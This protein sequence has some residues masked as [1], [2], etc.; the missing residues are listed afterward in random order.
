[1]PLTSFEPPKTP[2]D[3]NKYLNIF[4]LFRWL[5]WNIKKALVTS[6]SLSSL[7]K[8][9]ILWLGH[10]EAI[11]SFPWELMLWQ[12]FPVKAYVDCFELIPISHFETNFEVDLL[13]GVDLEVVLS[14]VIR[15]KANELTLVASQ[16]CRQVSIF[17]P[18]THQVTVLHFAHQI[19]QDHNSS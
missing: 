2:Y 18:Q 15:W 8:L 14:R 3:S 10:W 13:V 4:L 7:T 12:A 11:Y 5:Y 19:H 1:M 6:L 16:T 9:I 17:E